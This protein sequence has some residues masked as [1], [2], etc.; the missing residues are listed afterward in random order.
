MALINLAPPQRPHSVSHI[1]DASEVTHSLTHSP[2]R[3]VASPK[4]SWSVADGQRRSSHHDGAAVGCLPLCIPQV[5]WRGGCAVQ[6]PDNSVVSW[7]R[8][9]GATRDGDD[10]RQIDPTNSAH[11]DCGLSC[12]LSLSVDLC[13]S[14]HRVH[15]HP[16]IRPSVSVRPTSAK[17]TWPILHCSKRTEATHVVH[18]DL[19]AVS[20]R[21]SIVVVAV[22][23]GELSR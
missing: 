22:D 9:G 18:T 15:S 13:T 4:A 3:L 21:W 16:P 17:I 2:M 8:R 10:A 6:R 20:S 7:G 23:D 11:A 14:P 5:R 19:H 1:C 12:T